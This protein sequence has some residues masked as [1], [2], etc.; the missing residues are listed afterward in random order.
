MERDVLGLSLN[1]SNHKY[2]VFRAS[3]G[4]EAK[5]ALTSCLLR[6]QLH[7]IEQDSAEYLAWDGKERDGS[8]VARIEFIALLVYGGD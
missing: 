7:P 3:S 5:L 4:S 6:L 2:G 8:V 1:L